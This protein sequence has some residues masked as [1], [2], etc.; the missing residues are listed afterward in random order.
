MKTFHS[1]N[2][3]EESFLLCSLH[4]VLKVWRKGSSQ[5][6]FNLDIK[7][8]VATLQLNFQLGNPDDLHYDHHV[9]PQ[10]DVHSP[11]HHLH[12]QAHGGRR[13]G[14]ARREKDRARAAAHRAAQL[15]T[16]VS[17]VSPPPVVSEKTAVPA[18]KLPFSGNMLPLKT[19]NIGTL[20]PVPPP[21]SSLSP[22]SPPFSTYAAAVSALPPPVRK[23]GERQF[24]T[25]ISSAKKRLFDPGPPQSRTP[26]PQPVHGIPPVDD[27]RV[28]KKSNFKKNEDDLFKKLFS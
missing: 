14:P 3:S 10:S 17:A 26:T 2:N 24:D 18:V 25:D 4:E 6:S 22:S 21:P 13:K 5:A 12:K 27:Q 11:G 23:T 15:K 16:A 9:P 7:D 1:S 8:G 20:Q 19:Q 28:G